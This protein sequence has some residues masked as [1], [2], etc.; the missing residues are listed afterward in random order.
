VFVV[1]YILLRYKRL[2]LLGIWDATQAV[3]MTL[4]SSDA[5][6]MTMI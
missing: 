5:L 2:N 1:F 3:S 4:T 6:G